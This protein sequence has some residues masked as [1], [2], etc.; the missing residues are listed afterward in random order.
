LLRDAPR[1]RRTLPL[2]RVSA[3]YIVQLA[4]PR[5][6]A[7]AAV[8]WPLASNS[9]RRELMSG[10]SGLEGIEVPMHRSVHRQASV[11]LMGWPDSYDPEPTVALSYWVTSRVCLR[12][13]NVVAMRRTPR[14][15]L[16][17]DRLSL[18]ILSTL[19]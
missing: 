18:S 2:R 3:L 16:V 13:S 1:A 6:R 14:A 7:N 11:C 12:A 19:A 8:L 17:I 5:E 4:I 9:A 10:E 15:Y